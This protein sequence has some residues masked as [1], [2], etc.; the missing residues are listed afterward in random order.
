MPLGSSLARYPF[1]QFGWVF[2]QYNL[3]MSVFVSF[4]YYLFPEII[5]FP[6]A[7]KR[8]LEY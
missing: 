2:N 4:I 5:D 1:N 3:G 7:Y 6:S 8:A